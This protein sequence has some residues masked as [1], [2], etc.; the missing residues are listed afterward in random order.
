[1]ATIEFYE[2]VV[3]VLRFRRTHL[4]EVA[5]SKADGRVLEG[6]VQTSLASVGSFLLQANKVSFRLVFTVTSPVFEKCMID[7]AV[8]YEVDEGVSFT[9][10]AL[11][12]FANRNAAPLLMSFAQAL[13]NSLLVQASMPPGVLPSEFLLGEPLFGDTKLPEIL[14]VPKNPDDD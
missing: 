14:E 12:E 4:F 9:K 10:T 13:V 3:D 5:L 2:D 8:D 1:M 7:A 6:K 11:M